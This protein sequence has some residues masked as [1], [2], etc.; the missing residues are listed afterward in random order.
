VT[1]RDARVLA[2]VQARMSS[3]RLPGKVLK[4]LGGVRVLDRV[5]ARL[6]PATQLQGIVLATSVDP[7]DDPIES[8]ATG[9]SVVRGPLQDVL[10]RYR[11]ALEH[12]PCDAIVRITADCPLIDPRV[13]DGVVGR[14]RAGDED[15]VANVI[16]VRTFP[17]GMDTEVIS[18]AALVDAAAEAL[19]P[20]DREHVTPFIR[21]RP[22]RFRQAA[23]VHDP[24][25]GEVRLTLDTPEDLELLRAVVAR[26]GDDASMDEL[27]AAARCLRPSPK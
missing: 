16:G 27:V 22:E 5:L 11:L 17:V 23:V 1:R 9:I 19:S 14:W 10:E 15:Y 3:Q 13:V 24:P 26:T 21:D 8:A 20:H 12:H 6:A 4:E 25:L 7:S 2:V 18:A